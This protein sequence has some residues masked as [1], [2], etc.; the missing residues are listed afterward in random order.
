MW[1]NTTVPIL[2]SSSV[3]KRMGEVKRQV[4]SDSRLLGHNFL[5]WAFCT[6]QLSQNFGRAA[7]LWVFFLHCSI[8][9]G[10]QGISRGKE[11]VTGLL[12]HNFRGPALFWAFYTAQF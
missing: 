2:Q 12:G 10:K 5:F 1:R 3:E 4:G 7:L 6:A 9:R 11:E 8:S